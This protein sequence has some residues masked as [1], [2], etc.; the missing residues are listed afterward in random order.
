M[1]F[2]NVFDRRIIHQN[3]SWFMSETP[4]LRDPRR[5]EDPSGVPAGPGD[6]PGLGSP[7]WRLVPQSPDWPTWMDHDAHADDEDPG[8]ADL[9]EDPDHAPP[10]GLDDAE[11]EVLLAEAREAAEDQARAEAVAGRLGHT[12]VLAAV[13]AVAAGRR[14]PGMPGSTQSF[15]GEYPSPAAGF[16]SGMPLDVAPGGATLGSFLESTAG[17]EDRYAGASDDE[18][19]GVICA[20]D[21]QEAHDS[22]RKHAAVAE[23]IR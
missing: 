17:E 10:S 16:A 12:P 2:A 19:L 6:R 8:D 1:F 11:L 9:Y 22:T 20:W 7:G 18:L 5:D 3:G 23:F 15:A 13:G 4:A 21:R 14:G